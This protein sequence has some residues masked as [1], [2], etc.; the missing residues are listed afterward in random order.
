[1]NVLVPNRTRRDF[2]QQAA[3][4][5]F[6]ITAMFQQVLE[7]RL[8]ITVMPEY[9]QSEGIDH[10]LKNLK[11]AGVS[12][13]ST[14]PYVMRS[15]S[16]KDGA[17]EPPADAG[18]GNVRLL[19]R[20]L[21]GKRKLWVETSPSF[22]PQEQLYHGLRYQPG[23]PD[24][25]TRR[26]G[27]ILAK[28]IHAASNAGLR[29][30]LQV[31][32]AIPPGYRV[33]FGG[34]LNEDKP[35]LP[36]GNVLQHNV[37]NNGSLASPSIRK[38]TEA[39]LQDL[40]GAYPSIDGIRVDW[41]EYPPYFLDSIFF[42]FSDPAE[43]AASHLG[44]NWNRMRHD[45]ADLRRFLLTSLTN[46]DLESALGVDGGRFAL[47]S[48]F[49]GLPG[50]ADLMR[51]KSLLVEQMLDGYLRIL[52]EHGSK[53][54]I[55]DFFP[56]PFTLASG[57]DFSVANKYCHSLSVK[58]YTMHWPMI[59]GF[60]GD[61]LLKSNQ[62]LSHELLAETLVRITDI[63]EHARGP[64]SWYKYPDPAT[65][66]PISLLAI[67]RKIAQAQ[68]DSKV[69]VYA[70]VHGYGPVDDFEARLRSAWEASHG[71]VWINRYAY[72]SDEKIER[73]NHATG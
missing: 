50:I 60:Y 45:A 41:P 59:V 8:G 7:K 73:I 28:F 62:G 49:Q 65:P 61:E 70:L 44:F 53:E 52:R 55:P 71:K 37:S 2:L 67:K 66:H 23:K 57:V 16:P 36:S 40:C 43:Q 1:M 56:P 34:P 38:Y 5:P 25:L 24:D 35:R 10:V 9:I 27:Q 14:S 63:D 46:E 39:L 30:Y 22:R 54:L 12:A 48:A 29:V 32:A 3:L 20:P 11:K 19:D 31:Q 64:L 18:A 58:L 51:F 4:S 26:D 15:V 21:W 42:D 17:L 72:L 6:A 47:L 33:Q 13:V 69:P 68:H